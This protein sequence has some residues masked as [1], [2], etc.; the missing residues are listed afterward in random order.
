MNF[1]CW[2]DRVMEKGNQI[3]R[4][5]VAEQTI[6]AAFQKPPLYFRTNEY[7]YEPK[8]DLFEPD[9]TITEEST[10]RIV[11]PT[12]S[13]ITPRVEVAILHG[14]YELFSF[15][16]ERLSSWAAKGYHPLLLGG[17]CGGGYL[18]VYLKKKECN[19]FYMFVDHGEE[20]EPYQVDYSC[21]AALLCRENAIWPCYDKPQ[22]NHQL[23]MLAWL[24]AHRFPPFLEE[25]SSETLLLSQ[26][27]TLGV[28]VNELASFPFVSPDDSNCTVHPWTASFLE[29]AI[30]GT[31]LVLANA[32][33][34]LI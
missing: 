13:L 31:T 7:I 14:N 3:Y 28:H 16:D 30:D 32:S 5:L 4:A 22:L 23:C 26:V 21:L 24:V 29:A 33:N 18:N 17:D 27:A 20:A 34:Y 8:T 6:L 25:S 11:Y 19:E 15:R 12:L 2:L 10:D 9:T 1:F